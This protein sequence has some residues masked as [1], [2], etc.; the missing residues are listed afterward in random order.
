MV[1]SPKVFQAIWIVGYQSKAESEI[2]HKE[3]SMIF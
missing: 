3:T 2:N 1:F